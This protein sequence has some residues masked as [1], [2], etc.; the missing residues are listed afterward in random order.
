MGL[1]ALAVTVAA[2]IGGFIIARNFVRRRLR[3]VDGVYN[4]VFP[5]AA[6]LFAAIVAWPI[7]VLPVVTTVTAAIFG[8]SAGV[9]TASGVKALRRGDG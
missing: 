9:G 1:I 2:A 3:F 6:G 5:F 7:A 8:I 4:P